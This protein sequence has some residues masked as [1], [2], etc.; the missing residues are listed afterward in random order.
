[1]RYALE[2]VNN[3][4]RILPDYELVFKFYNTKGLTKESEWMPSALWKQVQRVNVHFRCE[5]GDGI[6]ETRSSGFYRTGG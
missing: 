2:V 4:P 3:D 6:M 5:I 1:M